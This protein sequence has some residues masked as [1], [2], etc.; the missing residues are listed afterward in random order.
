M[1][2]GH[3]IVW[4]WLLLV[5]STI[6][7]NT[8]NAL[9]LFILVLALVVTG[10]LAGGPRRASLV[11]SLGAGLA[12]TAFWIVLT[13][14]MPQGSA[15]DALLVLPSWSPGP[16]VTFG[17]PL[18][19]TSVVNGLT[20]ALRAVAVLLLFG[21]AGQL[22]SARGWLA[23]SRST[24]GAGAPA[25]HPLACLGEASV[26]T[27]NVRHRVTRQGWGRNA[28]AGW[29]TSLLLA[30]R[31]T[32]RADRPASAPRPGVELVRL[33]LLLVLTAGPVLALAFG[34]LPAILTDNLFGTD[35]VALVVLLAVAVGLA[36]PGT[37]PLLWQ[38]RVSD[39]PQAVVALA[40]TAAWALRDV[41]NQSG[42][43]TP[44]PDTLPDLPWALAAAAI[45]LPL[46]V[47]LGGRRI[48][49]KAV[50]VHA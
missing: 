46:A 12:A 20:G 27:L 48:K 21:L 18:G 1:T 36:L 24:L 8:S 34:W 42:S 49:R 25:L 44:A 14:V 4:L 28:S 45:L 2:D 13:L 33:G 23:L 47:G 30:A 19:I 26:E 6:A 39:V 22:V 41:L 7:L 43:L 15:T 5:G 31:D 17:G 3:P 29:L 50:P 40:L 9:L 16:G 11:T 37:P 32:A 10:F 35:L 38:W